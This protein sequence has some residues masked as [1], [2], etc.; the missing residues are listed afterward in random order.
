MRIRIKKLHADAIVPKYAH[1]GDAAV[2]LVAVRKWED[3]YGNACYG[4]GLA[5][6]IPENHVGLLFPRSSISKTNLRLANAVGVVDSGYRGEVILKFDKQGSMGYEVG[7]RIGQ[8]MLLPIPSIQF[9]EVVN[10]PASDRDVG[11]FG[12]TG[13]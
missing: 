10:L 5:M 8:L 3:K 7:D 9:V 6:E 4:T 12:S 1:F 11:G 13:N 2:D